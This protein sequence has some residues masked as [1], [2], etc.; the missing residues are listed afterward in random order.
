[1]SSE[2]F[3][4]KN[5]PDY[6]LLKKSV[7]V[8]IRD[9]DLRI[10]DQSVNRIGFLW[11]NSN[12][13]MP[14]G[15]T[16]YYF[17]EL[18]R[19]NQPLTSIYFTNEII[20]LISSYE[21]NLIIDLITC[22]LSNEFFL[23]EIN[24]FKNK[25]PNLTI[26]YST[27]LT[28][29]PAN[30]D[31]IME[32]SGENISSIYFNDSI[33]NYTNTL[34]SL[35]LLQLTSA[36]RF[37]DQ[38][39]YWTI[40]TE[41][42]NP[43]QN[44]GTPTQLLL[45][46]NDDVVSEVVSIGFK[47][48]FFGQ[49]Y[50]YFSVSPN[51]LIQL[52]KTL[53]P[54]RITK[55]FQSTN[56][57][58]L[59]FPS[60]T[61]GWGDLILVDNGVR[62][63]SNTLEKYLI[64]EWN[65]IKYDDINNDTFSMQLKLE[66]NGNITY[67]FN[68][69]HNTSAS[70]PFVVGIFN[71]LTEYYTYNVTGVFKNEYKYYTQSNE[72]YH[73]VL[74][75]KK[76]FIQP[77]YTFGISYKYIN[78]FLNYKPNYF[79]DAVP[80]NIGNE[81]IDGSTITTLTNGNY[82][83]TDITR[84]NFSI[85][86][87]GYFKP[88]Y[89]G[90]W[91]FVITTNELYYL[92]IGPNAEN[93]YYDISGN[94]INNIS[95]FTNVI[96]TKDVYYPIR[97][98][99]GKSSVPDIKSFSITFRYSDSNANMIVNT[100]LGDG[101][102]YQKNPGFKPI[103]TN[104]NQY[105]LNPDSPNFT[106]TPP[107]SN[108]SGAF[109]YTSSNPSVVTINSTTGYVEINGVGS[110]VITA[111]QSAYDIYESGT[112]YTK[113]FI[114]YDPIIT[115]FYTVVEDSQTINKIT[116][117]KELNSLY[118]I[119]QPISNSPGLFTYTS[120]NPNVGTISGSDLIIVGK[121][122][123]IITA[124]Q[125]ETNEF[126]SISISA[127]IIVNLS[128]TFTNISFI[129]YIG[130]PPVKLTSNSEGLMT[131]SLSNNTDASI[132]EDGILSFHY[133][134]NNEVILT[135]NQ[136]ASGIF[137]ATTKNYNFSINNKNEGNL[138]SLNYN[139]D[140]KS[141]SD[142]SYYTVSQNN[143]LIQLSYSSGK[144]VKKN[145][146][147]IYTENNTFIVF[148]FTKS[149]PSNN[150]DFNYTLMYGNW[151]GL[152]SSTFPN[153]SQINTS[154]TVDGGAWYGTLHKKQV[155][156]YANPVTTYYGSE[157]N[158]G[159]TNFRYTIPYVPNNNEL[160]DNDSF[161]S[162]TLKFY[163]NLFIPSLYDAQNYSSSI[164]PSDVTGNFDSSGY[165]F[166]YYPDTLTITKADPIFI[167]YDN[168]LQKI[169][170]SSIELNDLISN[171]SGIITY[172]SNDQNIATI[173]NKTLTIKNLGT[174]TITITQASTNNYNSKSINVNLTI[175]K[176]KAV[177]S[178]FIIPDKFY[179]DNPFTIS[180]LT[181]T[182]TEPF[183]FSSSNSDIVSINSNGLM[184]IHKVGAVGDATFSTV[185]ISVT[186]LSNNL[187]DPPDIKSYSFKIKKSP[188]IIQN[189]TIPNSVYGISPFTFTL[190]AST[191]N[192][193]FIYS[194]SDNNIASI[195]SNGLISVNNAGS[196]II[197]I[198]Q[199][200]NE[201]Y[202]EPIIKSTTLLIEKARVTLGNFTIPNQIYGVT[203]TFQ[204]THPT[205]NSPG[206]FSYISLNTN[207]ASVNSDGLVTINGASNNT[208][209][210]IT[211]IQNETSNYYASDPK[212]TTF[213]I[214][215]GTL[216]H[217]TT[218]NLL[219]VGNLEF[220]TQTYGYPL[221]ISA[222]SSA[223][224]G[225]F[226]YE[227]SDL[228]I[229]TI[230]GTTATFNKAGTAGIRFIQ[231][232]TNDYNSYQSEFYPI[233]I[234]E[235]TPT[236]QSFIINETNSVIYGSLPF[237]F[238]KPIGTIN[239]IN[240][241]NPSFIYTSSNTDVATIDVNG[242]IT[243]VGVGSTSI[244]VSIAALS[245]YY[246]ASEPVYTTLNI[247]QSPGNFTFIEETI[248]KTYS[249]ESFSIPLP[250]TN[251]NGDFIYTYSSSDINYA[252]IEVIPIDENNSVSYLLIR[253]I[254][255]TIN[256]IT[257]TA[258][259]AETSNYLSVSKS[260]SLQITKSYQTLEPITINK[261]IFD[262]PFILSQN[263]LLTESNTKSFGMFTYNIINDENNPIVAYI[264][265]E[266]QITL[267][268]AGTVT[269][270]ATQESYNN[271]LEST[272]EIILN[273]IKQEPSLG[274][275]ILNTQTYSNKTFSIQM[276]SETDIDTVDDF[277]Y[278]FAV[279]ITGDEDETQEI[280]AN[281]IS[282]SSNNFTI[283]GVGKNK[284]KITRL[285]TFY[286]K[287]GFTYINLIV[288]KS[289]ASFATNPINKIYGDN[290]FEIIQPSSIDDLAN[291]EFFNYTY[292]I[293]LDMENK[294]IGTI[295]NSNYIQI[296]NAGFATLNITRLESAYYNEKTI[297]T[298]LTIDK[299]QANFI[300]NNNIESLTK[301]Y[302]DKSFIIALPSTD[303]IGDFN[304]SYLSSNTDYAT[305]ELE[306][307]NNTSHL[308]VT[309]NSQS[310]NEQII[311]TA[312]RE[313][314]SNYLFGSRSF[315]L[316]I[317]KSS[318]NLSP[319]YINKLI[320]DEPFIISQQE[321]LTQSTSLSSGLIS[322]SIT[323]SSIASSN[324]DQLISIISAGSLTFTATQMPDSNILESTINIILNISKLDL[325]IDANN[326]SLPTQT[327]SNKT[328]SIEIPQDSFT[329]SFE[330][331]PDETTDLIAVKSITTF[332]LFSIIGTG[333]NLVRITRLE[334]PIY[335]SS[336]IDIPLIITKSESTFSLDPINKTYGVEQ[337]QISHPISNDDLANNES[338]I[339]SYSVE[340][341]E[342]NILIASIVDD[343]NMVIN[344]AGT[345]K[346]N[347]TRLESAYYSTKTIQTDITIERA[348]G[349][350]NFLYNSSN[351]ITKTY[352]DSIFYID[353]P[354]T[355]DSDN[356]TNLYTY[357]SSNEL[358]ATVEVDNINNKLKVNILHTTNLIPVVITASRA[359]TNRYLSCS[360]TIE[361]T[362]IKS[363]PIITNFTINQII[364]NETFTI[365]NPNSNSDGQF[366]FSINSEYEDYATIN[367]NIVTMLQ[368]GTIAITAIQQSTE[369]F[370][371]ATT[372]ITVIINKIEPDLSNLYFEPVVF[373]QVT[374]IFINS[375][376]YSTLSS[377]QISFNSLNTNVA[378]IIQD[379]DQETGEIKNIINIIGAGE[380]TI[381]ATQVTNGTY[382]DQT[383]STTLVVNKATPIFNF[384]NFENI[385][386]TYGD[387]PLTLLT[388]T[389]L[390]L[391]N[392][393][394]LY[395]SSNE[396]LLITE[397]VDSGVKISFIGATIDSQPVTITATRE[398]SNNYLSGSISITCIINKKVQSLLDI[399]INKIIS[400]ANFNLQ[401]SIKTLSGS[402]STGL[403]T[404]QI[405]DSD[406]A[407]V[408]NDNLYNIILLNLGQVM[409]TAIQNT[410]QNYTESSI[411]ITLNVDKI[412]PTLGIFDLGEITYTDNEFTLNIPDT[413]DTF[414]NDIFIYEFLIETNETNELIA[415]YVADN[416]F[417]IL[418]AGNNKLRIT[419]LESAHYKQGVTE[420]IL[421]ISKSNPT[422]FNT[423]ELIKETMSDPFTKII[424]TNSPS[425]IKY[426]FVNSLLGT[427][428]ETSGY[429]TLFKTAGIDYIRATVD[430]VQNFTSGYTDI[431]LT[432]NKTDSNFIIIF[433]NDLIYTSNNFIPEIITSDLQD[434]GSPF[435]YTYTINS[436][437]NNNIILEQ[438]GI[439][440]DIIDIGTN[441]I[442]VT[443]LETGIY[444][445]KTIDFN[446]TVNAGFASLSPINQLYECEYLDETFQ[447]PI[448]VTLAVN[449]NNQNFI[450]EFTSNNNSIASVNIYSGLVTIVK[451]GTVIIQVKRLSTEYYNEET[452]EFTVQI[453]K[454]EPLYSNSL[455]GDLFPI[456]TKTII[457]TPFNITDIAILS[458][459]SS[460]PIIFSSSN[461][462]IVDISTNGLITINGLGNATI[463]ASVITD[464][465]FVAKTIETTITVIKAQPTFNNWVINEI[466]TYSS[467]SFDLETPISNDILSL[468]ENFSYTYEIFKDTDTNFV[469][470]LDNKTVT[471]INI[472][473][474]IIRATRAETSKYFSG[475]IECYIN[476][477]KGPATFKPESF[478]DII[479]EYANININLSIPETNDRNK[480]NEIFTY[481][482]ESLNPSVITINSL[483]GICNIIKAGISIIRVTRAASNYYESGI[484]EATITVNKSDPEFTVPTTI[485]KTFTDN[486]VLLNPISTN[487]GNKL[488][489]GNYIYSTNN[490]EIIKIQGNRIL[491]TG[492]GTAIVTTTQEED[493]NYLNTTK[494]TIIII[495]KS[496]PIINPYTPIIKKVTDLP[497][498]IITPESTNIGAFSYSVNNNQVID[499]TLDGIV[500]INGPGTA[501]I[502][503]IQESTLFY[504]Q[505][506]ITITIIVKSIPEISWFKTIIKE[507]GSGT[508]EIEQPTSNSDG[509]FNY[510]SSNSSVAQIINNNVII[511]GPG[512]TTITAYQSTTSTFWSAKI[513]STLVI[514]STNNNYQGLDLS[515]ID[516]SLIEISNSNLSFSNL[517][518]SNLFNSNLSK[519]NLANT[520]LTSSNLTL[521]NL[522]DTELSNSILSDVNMRLTN[523]T[524]N[525][526]I[527]KLNDT[528]KVLPF[529]WEFNNSIQSMNKIQ[530]YNI[531][532]LTMIINTKQKLDLMN[533]TNDEIV[534]S[535]NQD[536]KLDYV[537][538]IYN[539][540]YYEPLW[541][542]SH[543]ESLVGINVS[544]PSEL[545]ISKM[546][547]SFIPANNL[548]IGIKTLN[549]Q[550]IIGTLLILPINQNNEII[551]TTNS[552]IE[553]NFINLVQ[554][555]N[556]IVLYRSTDVLTKFISSVN[557][558]N[559]YN[560]NINKYGEF[561][562][563]REFLLENVW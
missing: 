292:S 408:S 318:Q 515:S 156:I 345:T 207:Y 434:N 119:I 533:S 48:M 486:F 316:L 346:L 31:W 206:S 496:D 305:I 138:Y 201:N 406:I 547:I 404:Y 100:S 368:G 379:I 218:S 327:Y 128:S 352:A 279:E 325:N 362:I 372:T 390:N 164:F 475:Y 160:Y 282:L 23:Q 74:I 38:N 93:N 20:E 188:S 405:N 171:S 562:I 68:Q 152:N 18:D 501:I 243:T 304:Y 524:N 88:S 255:S 314:T 247:E 27:N 495:N 463:Y 155:Y 102:L 151:V 9:F 233:T 234:I 542:I 64:I 212:T 480:Y 249:D 541:I 270:T 493:R 306:E 307:L 382:T 412:T 550:H 407:S 47:F 323:N 222:P 194:T 332:N 484:I 103:L 60:I 393:T 499:I 313:E 440:F 123:T 184:T 537:C 198:G 175:I 526:S 283:T 417:N 370:E 32:S 397:K 511:T 553:I 139:T 425:P 44:I 190:P 500:S 226:S 118:N 424:S 82:D 366:V 378:Q 392:F 137:E 466:L 487:V 221:I 236:L 228:N 478:S 389:T 30:G 96:L 227:S 86:W 135:I 186:Q 134:T 474:N 165:I 262:E 375:S 334:T 418:R 7:K 319:V 451:A 183:I 502:N 457:T 19:L 439:E 380:T 57:N 49:I 337:F 472:G 129:N 507:L 229:I 529:R 70:Y 492:T 122:T 297:Q 490:S 467:S 1:M 288:T 77:M 240:I 219:L 336:Y 140:K 535:A 79:I 552:T 326:F 83:M 65:V 211:T 317:T 113:I 539:N 116:I 173:S 163:E 110:S 199:N 342:G 124:T 544:I 235:A 176:D 35:S 538:K 56:I 430:E 302:L 90:N 363:I 469:A 14:F 401:D 13:R 131:F 458:T 545:N 294:V 98:Q 111:T 333:R 17:D 431:K 411:N 256:N 91:S 421:N 178:N 455:P 101:L 315:N 244:G 253:L 248:I 447:L 442:T 216:S 195:D 142:Y 106:I 503:V 300:F 61:V 432:V 42:F 281:P 309:L 391:G 191:S 416:K 561:I 197:Y 453:N 251:D 136:E 52:Q 250:T 154:A 268:S 387:Q 141:L 461:N 71:S 3:I 340:P 522:V 145:L 149:N 433:P 491:F 485:T 291:N 193:P 158:L 441:K 419:R 225:T 348:I 444:K 242:I 45:E 109:T 343:N 381:V 144:W 311:I 126:R 112:I 75:N 81:I 506:E 213:K 518:Y 28:G 384:N 367:E 359:Q 21:S 143:P 513:V 259:K 415:S 179:G 257:I 481:N 159:S 470:T 92:W 85:E 558:N 192:A 72:I 386:V 322:Y 468:D 274:N 351:I 223:S 252:T 78:R 89:T 189:F 376:N 12:T 11:V 108:S 63:I 6:D 528:P 168:I 483:S 456:F 341:I 76:I 519:S 97:I 310:N 523:I 324:S 396:N 209:I 449:K 80:Y 24:Y 540:L 517:S 231:T 462:S 187:Y 217:T 549:G 356:F 298:T 267:V 62:Y 450:Y 43:I 263:T 403:V 4:D 357:T 277:I 26:N 238:T 514:Y 275:F 435:I 509:L 525:S 265:D 55:R 532:Y 254:N 150:S 312:S 133:V 130:S 95:N 180:N 215:K 5:V 556:R 174:T 280:I 289:E 443:R 162:V 548:K 452:I 169:T 473:R 546:L 530:R 51:G 182:S 398:E 414:R 290:E 36:N 10:L 471:I 360:N 504:I 172:T 438:S 170:T 239:E 127:V 338:F 400:D 371:S 454:S 59:S 409:F 498:K 67:Y 203:S 104:F 125:E 293:D 296:N 37:T 286:Y 41:I 383:T 510:V 99:Y 303:D 489:L 153:E 266:Q 505:K 66:Q 121:G 512:K 241:S 555:I 285:E 321:M 335:N 53:T 413:I 347:I 15:S 146:F 271:Y 261:I 84:N 58:N 22:N 422:F 437:S 69:P 167:P 33:V 428:E 358:N 559:A 520:D 534:I 117:T 46:G 237:D 224:T 426:T 557:T 205:S 148:K 385:N 508:F 16:D 107:T 114:Q 220:S 476:V 402:Q 204:I 479:T 377:A 423:E 482:F 177:I 320:T 196:V 399:S 245:D 330:I 210:T 355:N 459:N 73:P 373:G 161:S 25:F 369:N 329:Y 521:T 497:F 394:Y 516:L 353:L 536:Q 287:S 527:I 354:T 410:D 39:I 331:L 272:V 361:L 34:D 364:S 560:V 246:I 269:F 308:L 202:L 2:I 374:S 50:E 551:T 543:L 301:T 8:P 284:I 147:A 339:Y 260:F 429:I 214:I 448:P 105:T 531:N 132:T 120:S 273:V 344:Y 264:N 299:A 460:S 427:I 200:E 54:N 554:N 445:E 420:I 494:E 230:D 477:N 258:T 208:D 40:S 436:I 115:D 94:P 232:E 488:P 157:L 349:S 166:F 185:T 446:V 465:N 388:P 278:N 328:F 395:T 365:T 464:D 563:T 181:S 87:T 295:V 350:F 29:N 276:P